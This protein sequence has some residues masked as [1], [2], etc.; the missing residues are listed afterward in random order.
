MFGKLHNKKSVNIHK[1][2]APQ[3]INTGSPLHS[4]RSH[5]GPRAEIIE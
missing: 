4:T 5:S 2:E 1:R 3:N